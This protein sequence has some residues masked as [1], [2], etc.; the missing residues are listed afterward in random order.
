MPQPAER[1]GKGALE[2]PIHA[3]S[4]R[5]VQP[6]APKRH[7]GPRPSSSGH[8][9][10]GGWGGAG[11]TAYTSHPTERDKALMD[12]DTTACF[13]PDLMIPPQPHP[14]A[15]AY[16][17]MPMTDM[18]RAAGGKGKGPLAPNPNAPT[19]TGIASTKT[20]QGHK[21]TGTTNRNNPTKQHAPRDAHHRSKFV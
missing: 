6:P 8:H 9:A 16:N 15:V 10:P 18:S 5:D 20:R 2:T 14:A 3:P 19:D 4:L 11:D 12:D 17:P 13:D 1:N 21:R 7:A